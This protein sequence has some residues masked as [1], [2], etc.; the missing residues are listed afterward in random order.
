MESLERIKAMISDNNEQ[1]V[2]N[3]QTV[4]F[5]LRILLDYATKSIAFLIDTIQQQ[6]TTHLHLLTIIRNHNLN[7]L[8]TP[9]L[10]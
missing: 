2:S 9:Q 6:Q 7:H 10:Q 8:L 4:T 3:L 1:Q 5:N